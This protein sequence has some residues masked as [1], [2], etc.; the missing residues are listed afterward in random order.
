[1]G[2]DSGYVN[3]LFCYT[4]LAVHAAFICYGQVLS[5]LR[6]F[7]GLY[8]TG[9]GGMLYVQRMSGDWFVPV[10][11]FPALAATIVCSNLFKS[12]RVQNLLPRVGLAPCAA[13]LF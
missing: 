8:L 10:G 3:R 13:Y 2:A 1:M 7:W 4:R 6:V 12:A 5:R 11:W 9:V